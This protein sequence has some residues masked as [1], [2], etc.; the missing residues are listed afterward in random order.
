M[1][2]HLW[3]LI[4]PLPLMN[5]LACLNGEGYDVILHKVPVAYIA[6][7]AL[8]IHAMAILNL[9]SIAFFNITWITYFNK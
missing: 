5:S 1:A 3:G 8:I 9:V 7:P 4:F 2:A 6:V